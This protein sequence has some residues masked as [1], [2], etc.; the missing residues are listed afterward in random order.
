MPAEGTRDTEKARA[1]QPP[2]APIAAAPANPPPGSLPAAQLTPQ[3]TA[4]LGNG[5]AGIVKASLPPAARRYVVFFEPNSAELSDFSRQIVR[6][7]AETA[8]GQAQLVESIAYDDATRRSGDSYPIAAC[9]AQAVHDALVAAGM[10]ADKG[11][12]EAHETVGELSKIGGAPIADLP[13]R[14]VEMMVR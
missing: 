14:R 11:T 4:A 5:R 13:C 9:R 10:P 1:N 7:L 6:K 2:R 12:I 3:P 8:R